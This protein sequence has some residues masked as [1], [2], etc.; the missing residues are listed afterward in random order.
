MYVTRLNADSDI[1]DA[2][3]PSWHAEVAPSSD[4]V[5]LRVSKP[6]NQEQSTGDKWRH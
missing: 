6:V 1:G 5:E 3:L 4:L 2:L